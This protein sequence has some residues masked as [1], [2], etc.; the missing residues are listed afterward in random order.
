VNKLMLLCYHEKSE[1]TTERS[2]EYYWD[3]DG[4]NDEGVTYLTLYM[5]DKGKC[6]YI[7]FTKEQI[8]EAVACLKKGKEQEEE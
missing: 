7:P 4:D 5:E 6:W 8:D 3:Y 2:V 1:R